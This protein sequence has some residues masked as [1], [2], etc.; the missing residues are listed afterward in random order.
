LREEEA[1][2]ARPCH[3]SDI[4]TTPLIFYYDYFNDRDEALTQSLIVPNREMVFGGSASRPP[5]R[6]PGTFFKK[7]KK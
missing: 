1:C 4:A 3:A 6:F 7:K 2:D 5:M